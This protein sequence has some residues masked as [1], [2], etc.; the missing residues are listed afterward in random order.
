MYPGVIYIFPQS[1]LSGLSI[2]LYYVR[3]LSAQLQEWKKGRELPPSS[4][5]QQ[6]PALPSAPAVEP[7][8]HINDQHTN[9]QFGK[10][11][12]IQGNN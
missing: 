8:V 7:R 3:E 12:I 1:V 10:L 2:F 9:F 4:G 6:F 11:W 5:T